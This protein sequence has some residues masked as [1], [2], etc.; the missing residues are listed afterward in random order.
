MQAT[1][2][3]VQA[4][5]QLRFELQEDSGD[6]FPKDVITQLLLLYDVCR[7]LELNLFQSRH[8]LGDIG[9]Q[10]VTEYIQRPTP[11]MI[12]RHVVQFVDGE[13]TVVE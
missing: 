10:Y 4:L 2:Q 3:G 9:W 13:F 12:D 7:C 6:A 5:R 1:M 8:V 11:V